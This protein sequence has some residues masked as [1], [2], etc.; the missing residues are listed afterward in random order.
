M[1]CAAWLLLFTA[2][3]A[4]EP[5]AVRDPYKTVVVVTAPSPYWGYTYHPYN[6]IADLI[7][8]QGDFLVSQQEAKLKREDARQK[9]LETQRKELE[10]WEW[11]R[12]FLHM[13][14]L[15][16]RQR[17]HEREVN[18]SRGYPPRTEICAAGPLNTLLEELQ[19]RPDL[20]AAEPVAVEPEWLRYANVTSGQGGNAGL[21]KSD[22]LPWPQLLLR[23]DFTGEREMIDRL[24]MPARDRIRAGQGQVPPEHLATLRLT[25]RQLEDRVQADKMSHSDDDPIW[26]T[27]H[28]IES[29]RFLRQVGAAVQLLEQPEA[30]F[31]LNPLQGKTVAE[32]V[33][34]MKSKGL[35]FAPAT[36]G[37]DRYYIALHRA[38]ADQ[39]DRLQGSASQGQHP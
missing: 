12:E 25:V 14:D 22:K 4:A 31:Y 20:L 6:P 38:L 39:V 10:H 28:Y 18:R 3:A 17:V 33:E 27:R 16:E 8:A 26:S 1:A 9:G 11:R 21:L 13:A 37:C 36:V 30:E 5:P 32:L 2:P 24:L 29:Q 35:H 19:R 7:R 15:R 23:A 34:H